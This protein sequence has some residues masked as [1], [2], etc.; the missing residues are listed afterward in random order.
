M[1]RIDELPS[2]QRA[3][4][5]LVLRRRKSYAEIAAALEIAEP[6]VRHLAHDALASLAPGAGSQLD[7]SEREELGDFVLAQ[8]SPGDRLVAY[9][10]LEGSAP[11]QAYVAELSEQLSALGEA[12]LVEAPK[13][14]NGGAPASPTALRRE[15]PRKKPPA[16]PQP[17]PAEPVTLDWTQP[18]GVEE[19]SH[20]ASRNA[21]AAPVAEPGPGVMERMRG[22]ARSLRASLPGPR[23]ARTPAG[24]APERGGAEGVP[25]PGDS[26]PVSK[27]GGAALLAALGVAAIVAILLIGTSG[28]GTSKS[29]SAPSGAASGDEHPAS[30]STGATGATGSAPKLDK[31]IRLSAAD[32]SSQA[33]GVV[34]V[35]SVSGRHV[36]AIE[37]QRLPPADGFHYVLWLYSSPTQ[38]EALGKATVGP[39]GELAAAAVE[40]PPH[41]ANFH[42]V[43]LTKETGHSPSHPGEVVLR[44]DFALH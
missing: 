33:T 35:A 1:T 27:R 23:R 40:L 22:S 21:R 28:S 24:A 5:S 13:S 36:L 19:P 39:N 11:A 2:D 25:A 16:A 3:V 42:E 26:G 29:A 15:R 14:R 32:S 7:D 41:A 4:L 43:I 8:L 30:G 18:D 34:D 38:F 31:Q 12:A 10:N 6:E 17:A 9:D 44:G 20:D 37:A